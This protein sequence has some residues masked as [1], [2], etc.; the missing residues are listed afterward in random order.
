MKKHLIT[1][2]TFTLLTAITLSTAS[3]AKTLKPRVV[4]LT[5][6]S[7]W[8]PDDMESM[9]RL[10]AHADMFE[11]KGLVFTTGWSMRRTRDDLLDLIHDVIDA[12]EKDLPNLMKR[13]GQTGFMIDESRQEIGYWPSPDYLRART[14]RGS[15]VIGMRHIGEGNDS[16]GSSLIIKV[17][18]ED[19]D[20]PIWVQAWGG[21]NTL[22]QAIWRVR[23]D[24]SEDELSAFLEKVRFY[25][26]TDQDLPL[27]IILKPRFKYSSHQWMRSEFEKDLFFIWD[28]CAWKFQNET[29]K[30][31]WDKYKTHIQN[32]GNLGKI[33]PKYRF[34]VEGDTPAFLYVMP[35]GLNDPNVPEMGSWGGYFEWGMG[36]DK[37]TYAY[38]NHQGP[39]YDASYKLQTHVYE[40][41]FNNFAARMDWAKDGE[42]NRNPTVVVNS[43]EGIDIITIS[44][45]TG[46]R[47]TLDASASQDPDGD[48]LVFNWWIMPGP[49]TYTQ[50]INISNSNASK[51][52]IEVPDDSAGKTFHVI[53]EVTDDGTHNLT[54]YRR[55][56]FEVE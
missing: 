37:E 19:D 35:N 4:V 41:T 32:H 53:C 23:E 14:V 25:T 8:E 20:R 30:R 43:N 26:I 12:Y 11:I 28:E 21:G 39:V 48:D 36:P 34:G 49:G 54:S 17:A 51:A 40:A 16:D 24:R 15:K 29:G 38:T 33:Y 31:N 9:I 6:I 42:A 50:E 56:I 44:S 22:A 47:V 27:P 52:S 7:T 1:T 46:E 13:S 3:H 2:L 10:L 45:Q 5:D 18:D 55:V